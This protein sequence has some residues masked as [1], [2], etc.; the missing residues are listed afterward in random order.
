[1]LLIYTPHSTTRLQYICKFI[2]EEV[3]G[4]TYSLTT[5]EKSFKN[6]E[7]SKINYSHLKIEN[8][9]KVYYI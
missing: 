5:D 3:L 8:T 6:Y 7:G 4:A 2:F 9:L 1:M